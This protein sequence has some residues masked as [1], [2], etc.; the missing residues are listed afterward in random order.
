M[1]SV[2]DFAEG[3]EV[4]SALYNAVYEAAINDGFSA[5]EAEEKAGEVETNEVHALER[6]YLDAVESVAQELFGQ[7]K[8][9]VTIPTRKM[10]RGRT[11]QEVRLLDKIRVEPAETWREAA[12]EIVTLI[13]GVGIF[14]FA[15][16]AEFLDSGPYSPCEAVMKHLHWIK[17]HPDLYG[18][19]RP[20]MMIERAMR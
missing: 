2:A 6:Q 19:P 12:R 3:I 18:G 9:R 13:N 1:R 17:R 14:H 7:Y 8:L 10:G 20:V 4:D 5:E 15:S 11:R 16:L